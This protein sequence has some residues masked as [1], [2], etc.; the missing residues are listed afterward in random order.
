MAHKLKYLLLVLIPLFP[1]S[2]GQ[3]QSSAASYKLTPYPDLWYN[4]V[5]GLRGGIRLLGEYQGDFL[6]GAHRLD[7]GVWVASK[8]PENP[9]SYYVSLSEP[10]PFW[11]E[12][13]NELNITGA[14][15][16]RTG[17]SRHSVALSKRIQR[18]FNEL[19]HLNLQAGFV[20]QKHFDSDYL[21][22]PQ[23]WQQE[24]LSLLTF[25]VFHSKE[26]WTGVQ[27]LEL[28]LIQNVSD[29]S[30]SFTKV[31]ADLRQTIRPGSG[32]RLGIRAYAGFVSDQ[33]VPEYAFGLNFSD[34]NSWM[35]SGIMRARGTVPPTLIRNG[36]FQ[37]RGGANLR[38][39]A[40]REMKRLSEGA[41]ALY[42]SVVAVNTEFDYPNFINRLWRNSIIEDFVSFRSYLFFDA[43]DLRSEFD[44]AG[45]G[46]GIEDQFLAD[47][48][49]GFQLSLNI[50]DYLGNDRAI[51]IRYEIPFWLSDA[52][53]KERAFRFRSLIGIGTIIDL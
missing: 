32:F 49:Q 3:A 45:P 18:G 24:W 41:P 17:F 21:L 51:T 6:Q 53:G 27:T 26:L 16:I 33:T 48:G 38:G 47:A 11:S 28:D 9:V 52:P 12:D 29:Q 19:D 31:T 1:L 50:P 42:S 43:G 30:S 22:F 13:L 7:A 34:M 40:S 5:D 46:P 35:Y 44:P 15:S 4:S 37:F 8:W 14:S 36:L 39:Y 25:R 20:Q 10:L 23:L 2:E